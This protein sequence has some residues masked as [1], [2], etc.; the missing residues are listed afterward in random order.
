MRILKCCV[1]VYIYFYSKTTI[2]K[3]HDKQRNMQ[4]QLEWTKEDRKAETIWNHSQEAQ[5]Q[6]PM[7]TQLEMHDEIFHVE[8]S[9]NISQNISWNITGRKKIHDIFYNT[10]RDHAVES[11]PRTEYT[12]PRS[13]PPP[14][15]VENKNSRRVGY[16]ERS[17]RW[18]KVGVPFQVPS[19]TTESPNRPKMPRDIRSPNL[20]SR[21]TASSSISNHAQRP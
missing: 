13:C 14:R 1:I 12:A 18:R 7:V 5:L 2:S 16:T 11:A 4:T 20:V 9:L 3:L 19:A 6:N 21:E 8:I 17:I 10:A 15:G